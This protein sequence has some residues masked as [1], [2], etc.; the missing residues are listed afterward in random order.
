MKQITLL[1][2]ITLLIYSCKDKST[3]RNKN[4]SL[5]SILKKTKVDVDD[6][7]ESTTDADQT[8]SDP[9]LI[10]VFNKAIE[11]FPNDVARN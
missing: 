6:Q 1:I 5:S 8:F 7:I 9:E 11:A 4:Q 2:L 3:D 10:D